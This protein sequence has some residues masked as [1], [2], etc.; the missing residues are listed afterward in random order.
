M[1][2]GGILVVRKTSERASPAFPIAALTSFSF[3]YAAAESI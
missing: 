2:P 1:A 3:L